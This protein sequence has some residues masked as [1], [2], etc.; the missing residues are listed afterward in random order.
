ME[1]H[2]TFSPAETRKASEIIYE[3]IRGKIL[4]GEL[5][6]GDK[7]PGERALMEMMQRS[8]PTV[9]EAL[10]MLENSGLIRTVPGG[11]AVIREPSLEVIRLP[12]ESM[13]ALR[14]VSHA[15]LFEYRS[16]LNEMAAAWAAERRTEEDLAALR[17]CMAEAEAAVDDLP[18]FVEMD[19]R[20]HDLIASASHNRLAVIMSRVIHGLVIDMF[21]SV[22]DLKDEESRHGINRNVIEDH[23]RICRAIEVRDPDLARAEVH[24]HTVLFVDDNDLNVGTQ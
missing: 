11:G 18:L 19:V 1:S 6:P 10:R 13:I 7:L 3:Q 22:F 24:R 2:V 5:K 23:R 4:S 16:Y 8:R 12:I 14:S 9:R 15:E 20:F 21:T 17:A